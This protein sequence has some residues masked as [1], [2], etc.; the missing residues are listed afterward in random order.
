VR[1]YYT[2]YR[3]AAGLGVTWVPEAPA[4]LGWFGLLPAKP[5]DLA[6]R[7]ADIARRRSLDAAS[8][9]AIVAR[10]S[11]RKGECVLGVAA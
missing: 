1:F 2:E 6:A 8:S 7:H 3:E 4:G 9:A 11:T 5:F 10:S